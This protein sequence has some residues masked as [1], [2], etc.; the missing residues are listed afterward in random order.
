M[1]RLLLVAALVAGCAAGAAGSYWTPM[2][3]N[4]AYKP[5]VWRTTPGGVRLSDPKHEV[6]DALVDD[7]VDHVEACLMRMGEPT[8]EQKRA[9]GCYA[10][11]PWSARA[12]R[13]SDFDVVIAPDWYVS[14]CTGAQVFPCLV[15]AADCEQA[16]RDKPELQK[17]SGPCACR[18]TV[19]E[20]RH[21]VVAPNLE[22]LPGTLFT[23]VTGCVN[24]WAAPFSACTAPP[25]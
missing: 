25:R 13:R 10:A 12:V 21:V 8:L 2:G 19:Q 18:G 9:G 20:N 15:T 16:R 7:L 17:C 6:A 1:R 24:P 11:T 23:L 14:S 3:S 22:L 5:A 4:T